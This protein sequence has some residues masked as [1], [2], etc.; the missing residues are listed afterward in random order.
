M[1]SGFEALPPRTVGRSNRRQS[2]NTN[3][4]SS[5]KSVSLLPS[6]A[7]GGNR[8]ADENEEQNTLTNRQGNVGVTFSSNHHHHRST[9][10]MNK[11]F[12]DPAHTNLN[13]PC[14]LDIA[15]VYSSSIHNY[16]YLDHTADVLIHTWGTS[17]V[18]AFSY[19]ALAFWA[20]LV[21]PTSIRIIPPH[22]VTVPSS[23]SSS[24]TATSTTDTSSSSSSSIQIRTIQAKGKDLLDL[25]FNFLDGCLYAYGSDYFL[26]GRIRILEFIAPGIDTQDIYGTT[27]ENTDTH[28]SNSSS[29]SSVNSL[30]SST[31]TMRITAQWYVN[32]YIH[33]NIP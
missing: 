20:H 6:S 30:S 28:T 13:L 11:V 12:D 32:I 19:A 31:P 10:D 4:V 22:N 21:D 29:S 25:L 15:N 33:R 27:N 23:S 9:E 2:N 5:T 7:L 26:G 14:L 8:P 24:S 18:E 1:A 16:E 3:P 17:F